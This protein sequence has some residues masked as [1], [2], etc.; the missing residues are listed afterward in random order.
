MTNTSAAQERWAEHEWNNGPT[1]AQLTDIN[2]EHYTGAHDHTPHEYCT[3]GRCNRTR[4]ALN[5]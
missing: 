3:I 5:A 2:A 4:K 1:P